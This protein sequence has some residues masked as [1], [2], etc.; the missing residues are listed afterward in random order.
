MKVAVLFF[1]GCLTAACSQH[2]NLADL[3]TDPDASAALLK[4]HA[5]ATPPTVDA[6]APPPIVAVWDGY[7]E[8]S[9]ATTGDDQVHVVVRST[10]AGDL[11]ATVV[12]GVPAA[13]PAPPATSDTC[14]PIDPTMTAWNPS[15]PTVQLLEGFEYQVTEL[16]MTDVRLKFKF[17]T[18]QPLADWCACQ[19]PYAG[20]RFC[21]PSGTIEPLTHSD[22]GASASCTWVFEA[23]KDHPAVKVT[24]ACCRL[25][26]CYNTCVCD[27]TT[28]CTY[29]TYSQLQYDLS[30]NGTHA[31]GSALHLIRTQ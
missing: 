19:L 1:A 26:R 3:T 31:D 30:I 5:C 29:D 23:T 27:E 8:Q 22:G 9:F 11:S 12:F 6:G 18:Y 25:E 10:S 7:M 21:L 17:P 13:P 15:V 4:L 20:S 2:Q 24:T 28:G 16:T 14:D